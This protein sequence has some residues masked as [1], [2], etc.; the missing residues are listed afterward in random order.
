MTYTFSCLEAYRRLIFILDGSKDFDPHPIEM[1]TKFLKLLY[2]SLSS[3]S[4]LQN[5]A[6]C[7]DLEE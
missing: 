7:N 3:F 6:I 2:D 5:L 1:H 4:L